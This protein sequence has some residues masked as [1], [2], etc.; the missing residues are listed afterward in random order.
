[1]SILW[2]EKRPNSDMETLYFIPRS[3][4]VILDFSARIGSFQSV[5]EKENRQLWLKE[6]AEKPVKGN[7]KDRLGG[8]ETLKQDIGTGQGRTG[9]VGPPPASWCH[10]QISW[11]RFCSHIV[12]SLN[13][14]QFPVPHA[15]FG[16][17]KNK[18]SCIRLNLFLR[19]ENEDWQSIISHQLNSQ[20]ASW[21]PL[22]GDLEPA[23]ESMA[24][25]VCCWLRFAPGFTGCHRYPTV[26]NRYFTSI[27]ICT[28]GRDSHL[29]SA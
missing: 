4:K 25:C 3:K 1:M 16:W 9:C 15:H 6:K 29:S 12:Y 2:T 24:D 5:F 26:S 27:F 22:Q 21:W 23:P 14:G 10:Q 13:P 28:E 7:F 11:E 18:E 8:A 19:F 17:A 20:N